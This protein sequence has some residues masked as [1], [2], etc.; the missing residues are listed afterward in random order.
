MKIRIF[1]AGQRNQVKSGY[2]LIAL[3]ISQLLES[4]GHDVSFFPRT[5]NEIEDVALWIRPPHYIKYPEFKDSKKNVFFT[6]HESETFTDWKKDWPE[7]LNKCDAVI[8]PT[9]WNKKVFIKAGVIK[10]PIYIVPL[11]V[12]YKVFTGAKTNEFSILTLHDALG[13]NNSRED[14]RTTI[15]AYYEAFSGKQSV[16]LTIKSWNI[17]RYD[18]YT[19]LDEIKQ[20]QTPP[21]DIVEVD[22]ANEQSLNNLYAKHWLFVKNAKREGFSLPL[23]EAVSCDLPVLYTD[24][25]ALDW[26]KDYKKAR[27]FKLGKKEQLKDCFNQAYKQYKYIKKFVHKFSWNKCAERVENVLKSI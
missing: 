15:K 17:K 2:G 26:V 9:R 22:F 27:S 16:L 11:G 5:A 18:Y 7:L 21:I 24:I 20:P 19:F 14:W 4:F 3:K 25:P 1:D 8:V 6:M 13:S 12:D 23:L 10:P